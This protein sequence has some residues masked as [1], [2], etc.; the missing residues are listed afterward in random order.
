M[1]CLEFCGAY[2]FKLPNTV[3]DFAG[4]LPGPEP[5]ARKGDPAG[6]NA[7]PGGPLKVPEGVVDQQSPLAFQLAL[8][9]YEGLW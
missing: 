4:E 3:F 2:G 5:Q 6:L 7:M 1:Q 9:S 8:L